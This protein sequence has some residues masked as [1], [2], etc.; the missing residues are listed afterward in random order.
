MAN[1]I[2]MPS[3]APMMMTASSIAFVPAQLLP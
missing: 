3:M 2:A 1:D